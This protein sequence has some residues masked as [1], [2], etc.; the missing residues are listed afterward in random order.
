M[1]DFL[2]NSK[3]APV[4]FFSQKQFSFKKILSALT[5]VYLLCTKA[6]IHCNVIYSVA[7]IPALTTGSSSVSSC[8][9][10]N[11][12][13]SFIF[14]KTFLLSQLQNESVLQVAFFIFMGKQWCAVT[15]WVG[16]GYA[17]SYCAITV[18]KPS[19]LFVLAS[20][21]ICIKIQSYTNN[22]K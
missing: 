11:V 7:Q 5:Q 2:C 9:P 6:I 20:T 14:V 15:T 16:P 4:N 19:Q 17:D 3:S 12:F 1:L 21:L 8:V 13:S 18:C 10:F 22:S